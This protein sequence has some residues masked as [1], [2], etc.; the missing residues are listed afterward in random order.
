[1][2]TYCASYKRYTANENSSFKKK[3]KQHR[4]ID[5]FIKLCYL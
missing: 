5:S 2:E 1:M 3:T 4:L